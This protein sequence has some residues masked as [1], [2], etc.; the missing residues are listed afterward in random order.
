MAGSLKLNWYGVA[1]LREINDKVKKGMDQSRIL[2]EGD[3]RGAAPVKTGH[4]R[5]FLDSKIVTSTDI[6]T[7]AHI[8]YKMSWGNW[9]PYA[10]RMELGF[11]GIDSLGRHYNQSPRAFLFPAL[12]SN[13]SRIKDLVKG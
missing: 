7:T 12:E 5:A 1:R 4:L 9:V 3:A 8:G 11:I 6:E 13:K 2:V 10:P